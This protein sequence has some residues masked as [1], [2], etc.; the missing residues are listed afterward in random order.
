MEL[1]LKERVALVTGAARGIGRKEAEA[2]AAE[3]ANIAINDLNAD[4]AQETAEEIAAHFGVSAI[5]APCD[6]TDEDAVNAMFDEVAGRMGQIDIL[7]NNAG[8][9]GADVG[10]RIADMSLG[11]WERMVSSHMLSTFLCTRAA[12][13]KMQ[14]AGSGAIINTSSQNYTGGGRAGASNYAAAKGGVSAFTRT[15]AKELARDGIRVNAVAPGYVE[16]DLIR[17]YPEKLL[18]VMRDQNPM[19]RLCQPEEVANA[20]VFLASDKA[21]FI[22]GALL[23]IDGGKRDFF[24]ED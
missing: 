16:T 20:V 18:S 9:A 8:I 23:C 3:G 12:V 6:V 17:N 21:S 13:K 24:W 7:V 5:A 14:A 15:A 2:F 11:N 22:N 4:A 10:H 19:R 1:G